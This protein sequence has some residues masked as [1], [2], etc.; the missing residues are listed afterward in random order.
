MYDSTDRTKNISFDDVRDLY[1]RALGYLDG[2][3]DAAHN[4]ALETSGASYLPNWGPNY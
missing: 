2:F 1:L 3:K 4:F